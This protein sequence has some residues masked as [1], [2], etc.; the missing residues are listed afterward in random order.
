MKKHRSLRKKQLG[1]VVSAISALLAGAVDTAFAQDEELEEITVTGSRIVRRDL[2]APSPIVTVGT[3]SFENSSTISAESVLNQLPQFVPSGTQFATGFQGSATT[4]P[5]AA[6]LNLRGL[7]SNRNLVLID[8][9]RGQPANATLVIDINTIPQAAIQSVEVITGGASAVYGPDAMAGV[10]NFVL[11][12]DF[13]GAEFDLRTGETMEGDG[14]ETSFSGLFGVNSGDGRGNIMMG[15]DWTKRE[16]VYQVDRDFYVKGWLD[17]GNPLGQFMQATSY[18]AN[19]FLGGVSNWPAQATVNSL[20]P[21]APAGAVSRTSEFRFNNDNSLFVSTQGYGYKGPLNCLDYTACGSFT[22]VKKLTNGNLD[23]FGT[24]GLA[25]TPMKRHSF[26]AKAQYD[27]TDNIT[28]FAQ[29]N[30][31]NIEVITRG[32]IP[33][34][35]TVWQAPITRADNKV[36]PAGLTTLL[37]SRTNPAGPW[38]LYQV[39]DYNGPI[40]PLNQTNMWQMM[41]GLEGDMMDGDWSWEAYVSRGD[42]NVI[43][44]NF[45]LP[46]LQKYQWL[47]NQSGFGK[48]T[49]AGLGRGYI[50]TC[51]TGLPVFAEFTPSDDCMRIVD[52]R[53]INQTN[54][55]QEIAEA[56]LQGGLFDLPAGEVRFAAGLSYRKNT[57]VYQPGNPVTEV[58]DNPVGLFASNGTS[59]ATDVREVYGELLVPVI[60]GLDAELGYRYSDFNTAGGVDTYKAMFTWQALDWVSFR[61]GYQFA[62]RA[63]NTA[64]LFT[65]PTQ[66]VVGFANG[67]PCSVTT[68]WPWGNVAANP[69]RIKVQDLCRAIIG[70]NTSG[71]DTQTYSITGVAGAGGFHRQNPPYFPL[72]IEVQQGNPKVGP[73]EGETWTFGAV[74]SEP[75][76]IERLTATV[77]LYDIEIT[78]AISPEPSVPVYSRCL[79]AGGENPT[80]SATHPDC[81]KI[82]RNT[83]TGDREEVAA[84]YSNLGLLKTSGIDLQLNYGMDIGPGSLLLGSTISYLDSFE[85]QTTPTAALLDAKGTF[86][87][88]GQYDYRVFTTANYTWDNWSVGLNWRHLPEIDAA[89][90]VLAPNT[91]QQG[92]DSYDIFNFNSSYSWERYTLRFGVDNLFDTDPETINLIPGGDTNT[93]N[94]NPGYYD[95]LGRRWYLGVKVT[96]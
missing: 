3:E 6:T 51:T 89:A 9:R 56:N 12:D 92:A 95:I 17:P 55:T 67:D 76:G 88:G 50:V 64:E 28:A 40:E 20:F 91:T 31:S 87:Q 5:G 61:G 47:V 71:F 70:N 15:I 85:F 25:S 46:S 73:E 4:T 30:Y 59:G 26:F 10:V 33:P 60:E 86:D 1:L 23:Q 37:D 14:N 93:D 36:L 84:L 34:A 53:M 68:L 39:L 49:F 11:K 66:L 94:T 74:I 44:E 52:S 13:E 96:F 57:F 48:G 80:F 77:D 82:R 83:S 24:V 18:G 7:G 22:G 8:G 38:S 45:R 69:N 27:L 65:G 43:I 41:A 32:G 79:N 54:L 62:T 75:F 90:K 16:P 58:L 35:I 21:M 72:E 78:D 81:L 19:E 63:P 29:T 2:S 42:T